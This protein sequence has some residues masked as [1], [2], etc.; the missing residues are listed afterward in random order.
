MKLE[1]AMGIS[2]YS[3][4]TALTECK[5][6]RRSQLGDADVFAVR[7]CSDAVEISAQAVR[8]LAAPGARSRSSGPV[9]RQSIE[10]IALF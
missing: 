1:N 9:S 5:A 10:C 8:G 2:R 6:A 7:K 4:V 3:P